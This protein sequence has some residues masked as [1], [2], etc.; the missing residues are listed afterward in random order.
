M[1]RPTERGELLERDDALGEMRHALADAS[2]GNGRVV[3]VGGEAG[4]GKTSLVTAFLS[5]L[6]GGGTYRVLR[7]ACDDLVTPRELGPFHD[8]ARDARPELRRALAAGTTAAV[9]DEL[10]EELAAPTTVL[11][12]E[13][14]HW[15]DEASV[16][17]L[18]FLARRVEH[19]PALIVVTYRDD[20]VHTGSPLRRLLAAVR[21]PVG[22]RLAPQPLSARAVSSL[23]GDHGVGLRLHA[24][25]GGNPFFVT[26]LLAAQDEGVPASVRDAVL[27]RVATLGEP[28]QTLLDLLAVVPTRLEIDLLAALQPTWAD[29]AGPAEQRGIVEIRDRAL[30]FRH[31]LARLAV[32]NAMPATRRHAL[33]R[34]VLTALLD[35]EPRDD[36]RILHHAVQCGDS[37]AIAAHGPAAARRAARAGAHQQALSHYEQLQPHAHLLSPTD[38]AAVHEEHAW[39]LYNALRF[40]DAV[41]SSR[42][43]VRLR[44][45][46]AAPVALGRA[47][48]TLA[49]HLYLDAQVAEA[50]SVI[51]EAVALLEP[52][53]DAEAGA[54]ARSYRGFLQILSDREDEGLADLGAPL[55]PG[56]RLDAVRTIY[57]GLGRAFL[58]DPSGLALL[59]CGV[60]DAAARG[61][62]EFVALGYTALVK[63]ARRLGRD[64]DLRRYAEEGLERTRETDLHSHGYTLEAHLYQLCAQDGR[65]DEAEAGL[66]R[67]MDAAP[68]A[69]ILGRETLPH[70]GRLQLRRGQPDAAAL[71]E[72]AWELGLRTDILP[73]LVPA[74]IA[75]VEGAWLA[76]EPERE[77]RRA[78]LLLSRLERPGLE[79]YR[80]ELLRYLRRCGWQVR[81]FARCRPEHLLGLRGD[82]AGAAEAWRQIGDPYERALELADSGLAEPTIEALGVLDELGAAPAARLVRLRLRDLGVTHIP[83][84]PRPA[85][86]AHPAGLTERQVDVLEMLGDGLTNAEIAARLVVSIRTVDHHVSAILAKLGVPN[87]RDAARVA[88]GS[89]DR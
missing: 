28:T 36:A 65:W 58:G 77:R 3:L 67:L 35:R 62:R 15:A 63:A 29:A 1:T 11:V 74:G 43:A 39:E 38:R 30:A 78:E 37:D 64:D 48:V 2:G 46:L 71:L 72:R 73:V 25:T 49:W 87:R 26:E 75:L 51:D 5:R 41:R 59:R 21:S 42:I 20:E 80:G 8:L 10:L 53:D 40:A 85:T 89:S 76:G 45:E 66:R 23:A 7:G 69:G 83:R 57:Q 68:E 27:A 44:R 9:L 54:L 13:D 81:T 47:L 4:I 61:Q 16:D 52:T 79:R 55:P 17:A 84:G 12:V 14:V 6:A 33:D 34:A 31:D 18:A 56:S 86:R 24:S 70:L 60:D 88:N 50:G 22:V 19:R 82:W 32:A